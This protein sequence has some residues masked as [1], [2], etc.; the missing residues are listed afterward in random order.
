M[1]DGCPGNRLPNCG[2][3]AAK[4]PRMQQR[5]LLLPTSGPDSQEGRGVSPNALPWTDTQLQ[6]AQR[7]EM[8]RVIYPSWGVCW[9]DFLTL[10]VTPAL[11]AAKSAHVKTSAVLSLLPAPFCPGQGPR[12]WVGAVSLLAVWSSPGCSLREAGMLPCHADSEPSAHFSRAS[13]FPSPQS[14]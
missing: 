8:T 10:Q 5:W 3:S 14:Y 12:N 2:A 7:G 6:I 11:P 4:A 13:P 1:A 9:G